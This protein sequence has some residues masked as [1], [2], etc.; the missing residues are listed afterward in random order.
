[1]LYIILSRNRG[2]SKEKHR[3]LLIY[4]MLAYDTNFPKSTS[5]PLNKIFQLLLKPLTGEEDT[6]LYRPQR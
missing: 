2:A 4:K 1:M 3:L 6:A 5:Y